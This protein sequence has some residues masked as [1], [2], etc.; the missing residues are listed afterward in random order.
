MVALANKEALV[1]AGKL[2]TDAA[3][4]HGATMLPVDSEHNAIFQCLAGSRIDDVSKIILTASGGPFRTA[5]AEVIGCRHAGAGRGASELVDGREDLGRFGDADE[6][7]ARADRGALS[8]RPSVG[9]DRHPRSIPQSV[10]HSMVEFVDGSVLAQLGSPDMRIPIAYALAWPERLETP[11]QRLDLAA[12]ARLDFEAPDA[13]RFPALRLAREALEAGGAAPIVLNAAN[14]VAVARFLAGA[15]RFTDIARSSK[16]RSMSADFV[17]PRSI[18]DVLEIDRT[19]RSRADSAMKA[20]LPL[21][22]PQPPLWLI[23]VAFVCALGPLVF[24][25]ELGH[26][27]V[28]RLFKIPAEVFSIGFGRELFGWTDRQGTRWKVAWLPLGGYV[29]F[30]GDMTPASNP[31]DLE[32]IPPELR[33]RAF[34]L[35]PVW[36]RF[37]VVL[38]GPAANFLLAII[39]FAAFFSLAGT[40]RDNVVGDVVPKSAA[41]A[42]GIR[43]GRPDPLDRR[44]CEP[45]RSTMSRTSSCCVLAKRLRSKS[46][47]A[48]PCRIC[49]PRS[50]QRT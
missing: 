44:A 2:M 6:Q 28:A 37:L 1:T 16:R 13:T 12:I 8:V 50:A 29:R 36:Q 38:A 14:E 10:I 5:S 20:N 39:I 35:R 33:D 40:P 26:Y 27:L 21:M 18:A 17:N 45:R 46:S 22:F 31:A 42:A 4:A 34:Q 23:L 47:V 19:T 24:F 25:H 15:I 32:S 7:G 9:A 48:V 11:A 30:V 43:A 49:G 41:A 3:A